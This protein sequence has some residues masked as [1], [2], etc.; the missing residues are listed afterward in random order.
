MNLTRFKVENFRNFLQKEVRLAG[1]LNVIL[2]R[3]STGKTNL[4]E[5]VSLLATGE[6]FRGA[7]NDQ[8]AYQ[9]KEGLCRVGGRV[10]TG[11]ETVDLEIVLEPGG[12]GRQAVKRFAVN[13]VA[14]RRVDFIAH[15]RVVVFE[16]EDLEMIIGSPS[17]R[18]RFLDD[19]LESVDQDYYR[20]LRSYQKGLRARNKLLERIREGQTERASL[21]FWDRLLVENGQILSQSRAEFI[22][23]INERPDYFGDLVI[24]YDQSSISPERLARYER[25]EVAAG[26]TLVGPHRDDIQIGL[27][28]SGN[29]TEPRQLALFGSRGEQRLAVF[30]LKLAHLEY[31]V[32]KTNTRPVLLLDDIFSELDRENQHRLVEVIPKQQTI[33]TATDLSVVES[34]GL[35]QANTITL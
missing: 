22:D 4:L 31:V 11:S 32:E 21:F 34:A 29:H 1:G 8:L 25:Q 24:T 33:L 10:A 7:R 30:S 3:N 12:S 2:G 26:M 35:Q 16:P 20:A 23:Y 18:R 6:S 28:R 13:N 5:A 15:F 27:V 19:V 14:R 9:A 17:A